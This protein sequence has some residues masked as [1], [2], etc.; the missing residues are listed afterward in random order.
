LKNGKF[1]DHP[2]GE[3]AD[4]G[5]VSTF[6]EDSENRLW[7]ASR[8]VLICYDEQKDSLVFDSRIELPTARSFRA[9]EE[10]DEGRIFVGS[11]GHGM[12]II[13]NGR[14]THITKK[15]GLEESVVSSITEDS[16]GHIWLTGNLGM[17]RLHKSQVLELAA[18]ERSKLSVVLYNEQTDRLRVGEFNGG[19]QQNKCWLG[20]ERYIFP[21]IKGAVK[22]DFS[23]LTGNELAPP[24][25][26]ETVFYNDSSFFA[27]SL[28]KLDYSGQR[29][30]IR[31][32]ALSYVSPPNVRFK[33]I[34]EGYDEDWIDAGSERKTSY[35]KV[36]PGD[37][38]FKVIASN[39]EGIW[40][41]QGDE[42][43][44]SIIPPFYM[45][46]WFKVAS[47]LILL[48]LTGLIVNAVN[49]R[50]R[51][52]ER[53]IRESEKQLLN[54]LGKEQKLLKRLNSQQ[55]LQLQA[56][57]DTEEKERRRIAADLHDGIGQL[58][59]SVKINLGVAREKLTHSEKEESL[60]L[61]DKSKAAIDQITTELRNISYN[62]M[63]PSLERF[64]LA[65]AIAEEVSKLESNTDLRIHFDNATDGNSKFDP[66][67]EIIVFRAFQELLNNA[68]KHSQASEITIQLIQH[69]D[70]LVLMVEDDGKG[71]TLQKGLLKRDSSGL[72][73]LFSRID[74]VEGD[75]NI[76]S[77]EGSGTSVTIEIPLGKND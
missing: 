8:N 39:D 51:K 54:A 4:I 77:W 48:L 23:T 57:V 6:L 1:V 53:L 24:V 33:Y 30:D 17:S 65:S 29:M 47:I 9:I 36:P 40:N 11:Y 27:D 34:L 22:V 7:I 60:L 32:T 41:M 25:H 64:G 28:I 62:L 59:S 37:Y 15:S 55:K 16:K 66:K 31:F 2:A 21:T 10:D 26:V 45:T 52:S 38:T 35:S 72:K 19:V 3:K 69:S 14:I 42:V 18:G 71:F 43:R 12:F 76:D 5:F 63:P 74:Y 58:L 61:M 56:I 44:L 70:E 13:D 20:G 73:N 67:M 75:V 46:W 49:V 50:K 68:L